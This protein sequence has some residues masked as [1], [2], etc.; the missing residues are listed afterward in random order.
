[1]IVLRTRVWLSGSTPFAAVNR[2]TDR[3]YSYVPCSRCSFKRRTSAAWHLIASSVVGFLSASANRAR[4][5]ADGS[6]LG[7]TQWRARMSLR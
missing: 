3:A 1:M 4:L 5:T 6:A 2:G 7:P